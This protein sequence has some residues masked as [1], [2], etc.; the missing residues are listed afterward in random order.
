M[1]KNIHA[2][3]KR[4]ESSNAEQFQVGTREW[5]FCTWEWWLFTSHIPILLGCG[6]HQM[7]RYE[8]WHS[9]NFSSAVIF[10]FSFLLLFLFISLF[11]FRCCLSF[12]R[13][14]FNSCLLIFLVVNVVQRE[15]HD[16]FN[17]QLWQILD[18]FVALSIPHFFSFLV[19]L[20]P[21]SY[22]SFSHCACVY[23]CVA[24]IR[25]QHFS[26]PIIACA[27]KSFKIY[28][29]RGKCHTHTYTQIACER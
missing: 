1:K 10:F 16:I 6:Y 9:W 18:E 22:S 20:F 2:K 29:P 26:I 13:V 15:F 23:V 25:W 5:S 3:N 19:L 14:R 27:A 21:R 28:F 24:F 12:S 8:T 11:T 17:A 7:T 4:D